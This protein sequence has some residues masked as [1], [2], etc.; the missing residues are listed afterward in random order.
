MALSF[1]S[2][3]VGVCEGPGRATKAAQDAMNNPLLG[4]CMCFHLA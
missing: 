1:V 4:M 3:C 2:V